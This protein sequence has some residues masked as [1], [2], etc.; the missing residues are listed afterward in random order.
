[1]HS[2]LTGL[3]S[4][5]KLNKPHKNQSFATRFT[6]ESDSDVTE[7]AEP[8]FKVSSISQTIELSYGVGED[9]SILLSCSLLS[10]CLRKFLCL[11]CTVTA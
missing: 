1:M 5:H 7:D 3:H 6:R 8:P 11:Q 10:T 9:V 2:Y 4:T